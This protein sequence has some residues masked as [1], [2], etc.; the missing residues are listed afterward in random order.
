MAADRAQATAGFL[1]SADGTKLAYR[2]WPLQNA[3]ITFA[4]VHGLG[5]HSGRYQRFADGMARHGMATYALDLRGHGQSAGQRGHVDSWSQWIDDAAAF[6]QHVQRQ[7]EGEV[8][9]LGH[10]FG[11]VV[12]LS[13]IRSGRLTGAK[14]FVLSSPAL[15]LKA[16]VPAWK[17]GLGKVMSGIAPRLSLDN[18]VDAGTV[19]R[20]PEVVDAYR[21][22]P[23]VHSKIS[24]RLYAEWQ[25]AARENMEHAGEITL[26]FLVMA[27]TADRL[28]DSDGSR[29]L[30][31]RA[32][33]M[34]E[35]RLLEGR[36]HEPFNDLGSEEVFSLIADWL[37]RK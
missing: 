18:E 9:P 7:A 34:S 20:I 32:P 37:G 3:T 26:P 17:S 25:R 23:L 5:E 15:K 21:T 35:L 28:I 19:S 31:E 10:S 13:T 24:S 33:R 8:V 14:R 6:V 30:H 36:Y 12:M 22:D 27:G 29:E 4:V 1:S 16:K 11:G 2:G